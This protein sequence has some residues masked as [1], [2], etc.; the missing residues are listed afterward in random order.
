MKKIKALALLSGGLDSILATKIILNQGIKVEA[1]N[2]T[3]PFCLCG[4]G[5]CGAHKTAQELHIPL[6]IIRVGNEYLKM[7]KNPKYGYGKN[8][9]PCLDCRI[10]MF[11]Q[12]KDYAKEIGASFIFTGEVL[13][14]RPMSQHKNAMFL[15]E[16][17]SGLKNRILRPLSAKLLPETPMEKDGLV[18]RSKLLGMQGRSRKPQIKLAKD[19]KV[20]HYPCP[21]GGCLL[22][23]KEF[24]KKVQDLFK[25]KKRVVESDITLLKI[26]RHFRIGS[27][28]I[29]VGRNHQENQR[30]LTS[31]KITDYYFEVPDCG[32]PIT[33]LQGRKTKKSIKAAAGLTAFYS[34]NKNPAMTVNYGREK[35]DNKIRVARPSYSEIQGLRI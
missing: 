9:N 7:I 30:L 31:K 5:G 24:A 32:G 34:D 23:Y 28:K 11:K 3:S 1:V 21:S 25:Y 12:A 35:L 13:G 18:D 33:V 10:F 20:P 29:I 17:E 2:F 14:E 6:K 15:I 22:T 4:K 27:N 8:L 16:R 19:L 26:G